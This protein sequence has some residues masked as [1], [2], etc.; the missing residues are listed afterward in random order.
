MTNSGSK[1]K[2]QFLLFPCFKRA[3]INKSQANEFAT[4]NKSL[5]DQIF[6]IPKSISRLERGGGETKT[7]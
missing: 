7:C 2:Y 6:K 4:E 1:E 3:I 5:I